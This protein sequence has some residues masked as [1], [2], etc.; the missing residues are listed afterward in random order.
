VELNHMLRDLAEAPAPPTTVD[1]TRARLAGRRTVRRR[2]FAA[3][4]SAVTVV[5]AI[6]LVLNLVL[7]AG[8]SA[9]PPPGGPTGPTPTAA[10]LFPTA[11]DPMVRFAEAG[12]LPPYSLNVTTLTSRNWISIVATYQRTGSPTP[13]FVNLVA[14]PV[15][16]GVDA[17]TATSSPGSSCG[18]RSYAVPVAA[19][20]LGDQAPP[21][22]GHPAAWVS[23]NGGKGLGLRWEY[24]PGAYAIAFEQD[25]PTAGVRPMLQYVAESASFGVNQRVTLP[26]STTAIPAGLTP[27]GTLVSQGANARWSA[28]VQYGAT[29]QRP[30]GGAW[31]VDILAWEWSAHDSNI[32]GDPTTTVDGHPAVVSDVAGGGSSLI[33][34]NVDGVNLKL[35]TNSAATTQSLDGGLLGLYRSL[36]IQANPAAWT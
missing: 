21:V 12:G 26:F 19:M 20:P 15:G 32:F 36:R 31:P 17:D 24:V 3:V 25:Y 18:C 16:W 30:A 8:P 33:L 22:N 11:F 1:I 4:G 28:E 7:A 23:V 29:D 14:V 35:V 6:A 5:M 2:R 34:Y 9:P 13:A 10:S 27:R